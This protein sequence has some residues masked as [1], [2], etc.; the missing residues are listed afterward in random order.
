MVTLTAAD[1][2]GVSQSYRCGRRVTRQCTPRSAAP[3][4]RGL[5]SLDHGHG[6]YGI[7]IYL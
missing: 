3:R 6:Q 4:D 2:E 7:S 1:N 5:N